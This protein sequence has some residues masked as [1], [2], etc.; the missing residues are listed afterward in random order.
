MQ[1]V[2]RITSGNFPRQPMTLADGT[3]DLAVRRIALWGIVAAKVVAGWGVQW[4]IQWHVRIGRD[5]F[6][7]APHVMTYAG[8]AI[9]VLLSFW[10]LGWDTW[11]R[12]AGGARRRPLTERRGRR[13]TAAGGGQAPALQ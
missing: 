12:G 4:D 8:V 7:I 10:I 2:Q 1:G 3:T 5:S 13:R 11:R 6:W 9:T